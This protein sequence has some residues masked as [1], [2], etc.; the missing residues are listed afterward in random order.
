MFHLADALGIIE[1]VLLDNVSNQVDGL[2][3][4]GRGLPLALGGVSTDLM[5]L[6]GCCGKAARFVADFCVL[7]AMFR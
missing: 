4:L 6:S 2:N 5:F 3:A 1:D 7:A